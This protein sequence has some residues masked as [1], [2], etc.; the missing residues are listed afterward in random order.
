MSL[1]KAYQEIS[2]LKQEINHRLATGTSYPDIN[3]LF[4]FLGQDKSYQELYTMDDQLVRLMHFLTVWKAEKQEFPALIIDED[5]FYQIHNLKELEQ[6]YHKIEYYGL[7]IEN[8]VPEQYCQELMEQ[9]M[10][11]KVSGIA[12]GF[13]IYYRTENAQQN[14]LVAARELMRRMELPNAVLLLQLARAKY[15]DA[16]EFLLSEANCWIQWKQPKRAYELLQEIKIPSLEVLELL[17]R[18]R[19][20]IENE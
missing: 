19:Q 11:Q 20:V 15:P 5:I 7:R 13:I 4:L 3:A 10:E 1:E 8:Q 9:L 2:R 17:E 12:L 18:L 14:L 16:E 6:K